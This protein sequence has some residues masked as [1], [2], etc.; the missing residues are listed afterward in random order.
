MQ[1]TGGGSVYED[2]KFVTVEELERLGAKKLIGTEYLRAYMH[3]FFMDVRLYNKLLSIAQPFDY[4]TY[5]KERIQA[6]LKEKE[7]SRIRVLKKVPKV[8]KALAERLA[9]ATETA[10]TAKE[11]K[12]VRD[13]RDYL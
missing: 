1:E 4:E 9:R 3:G 8:N 5:R 7:Q 6:K 11:R 12:K 13:R 10:T 2:Y